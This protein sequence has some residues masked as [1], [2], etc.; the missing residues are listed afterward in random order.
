MKLISS[1][2]LASVLALSACNSN[3]NKPGNGVVENDSTEILVTEAPSILGQWQ[4]ENIVLNDNDNIRP[5]EIQSDEPQTFTFN[6]DST[7]S[8]QTNVNIVNGRYELKGDSITFSRFMTTRMAG[9][10]MRVE[11]YLQQI[12]P[13]VKSVDWTADSIVRLNTETPSQ[14][15]IL[16]R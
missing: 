11:Q 14:Y 15:I 16:K 7:F 2:A 4:M 9:P 3:A 13:A 12:L 6:T 5:T 8:A 1:M 10:D